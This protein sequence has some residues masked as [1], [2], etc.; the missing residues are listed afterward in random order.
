MHVACGTGTGLFMGELNSL[1]AGDTY[2][3][4][5]YATNKVGTCYGNEVT[6]TTVAIPEITTEIPNMITYNSAWTGGSNIQDNGFP[7][8]EKG[9]CWS[10]Q[11]HPDINGQHSVA[12][13]TGTYPFAYQLTGLTQGFRYYV[14]AYATNSQGTAY[15]QEVTFIARNDANPCPGDT[16]VT[17]FD[18]NIY[19]TVQI[20]EQCWLKENLRSTHYVD[21]SYFTNSSYPDNDSANVP[22]YGLM[23]SWETA[24]NGAASSETPGAVQG[25]CPNGW[26]LPSYSEFQTLKNYCE[27]TYSCVSK[28]LS[29]TSGWHY[30]NLSGCNSQLNNQSGFSAYPTGSL[31]SHPVLSGISYSTAF[32]SSTL[33]HSDSFSTCSWTPLLKY[34]NSDFYITWSPISGHLPVRCVRNE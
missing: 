26:H 34:S 14:R 30:Y 3:V 27:A 8:T 23:Y 22:I 4:R 16:T 21:G 28:A 33:H 12:D 31:D 17:D 9:I 24:M 7:I 13:G 20:G 29:S 5:A 11:P 18:G 1:S 19:H 15:G 10:E 32:W 25:I 2:Y 6:F